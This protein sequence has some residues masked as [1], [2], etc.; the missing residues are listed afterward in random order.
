MR[1]LAWMRERFELRKVAL[2][3]AARS[4]AQ[5]DEDPSEQRLALVVD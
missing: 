1:S 3:V 4:S 2:G 5:V